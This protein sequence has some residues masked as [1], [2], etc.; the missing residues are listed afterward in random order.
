M[1]AFLNTHAQEPAKLNA[2]E[3]QLGLKKLNTLGSV[4]YV[5]AHPDDE[6][7]RLIAYLSNHALLNTA[8]L[9]I[10]RGD[11]GQNLVGPEIREMLGV[12]R[13][14]EL[15]QARKIDGGQQ[16]F[17]RANDFGYSKTPD[18][19]F[20]IWDRE[21]VLSD[22]VWTI[23]KFQPDVIITRFPTT[24]EGGH[25][26]HTASAILAEEAFDAA[27]D[28]NRFPEQLAHVDVWQTRSLVLNTHPW[29]YSRRGLEFD[30]T[31]KV[32]LDVG[33]Y[34]QLLGQSYTEIAAASR[35][36]HKSQGFGSTGSR[37][38]ELEY[39]QHIKGDPITA[40]SFQGAQ[41]SWD[42]VKNGKKVSALLQQAYEDFNPEAPDAVVPAL[43]QALAEL[44]QLQDNYYA[45]LKAK[46]VKKLTQAALG[47][48]LEASLLETWGTPG[49][50]I[51]VKLEATN[52]SS[53][54]ITLES[55]ESPGLEG[56]NQ[57]ATL[58]PNEKFTGEM[59][60]N[61]PGDHP[62]SQP[63]W[64]REQGSVGMF[65]VA[66]PLM[67]GKPENDAALSIPM[68]VTVSGR[69]LEYDI[70]VVHKRNDAVD[71]EIF[72][73][74]AIAP[75][76]TVNFDEKVHVFA[77]ETPR[78]V[79]LTIKSGRESVGGQLNLQVPEGWKVSPQ[80][81]DFD[82]AQKGEEQLAEFTIYP[83]K[84]PGEGK[85]K[86][87]A[88]VDGQ[89]YSMEKVTISYDHIPDQMLLPEAAAKVVK[90][91]ILTRGQRIGYIMGAGDDIPASL[92][93]I[94]YQVELIP[95]DQINGSSLDVYDAIILGVRA[96]NTVKRLQFDMDK[97][98]AYAYRG[99]TLVV[100]YNTNFR[101]VTQD[102]APYPLEISR[103]RVA[104]EGA[105][106]RFLLPDHP[107][108]NTPNKIEPADFE[109]WVQER[110]LYFPNKWDEKYQAVLSTNDP[111]E[112]PKNGSL[113]VAPYGEGYYVYTGL[114]WF[115][116][117]PAGVPGAF[118]LFTNII[119]L[120]QEEPGD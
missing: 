1:T 64:L 36:M 44:D 2:A 4:L 93:Q 95:P 74:F 35:S 51:K 71:G 37:G 33:A 78:K 8:Y 25:G 70:P 22:V 62:Y 96:L 61:I 42:R 81:I 90:L 32:V 7:T 102:F 39:L 48:Y 120:G 67:I 109:A 87:I 60:L 20:T 69:T 97:L 112:S 111:G 100:Q 104:V 17:T 16:F 40:S 76:V 101:M 57:G 19:T 31:D 3:I 89:E 34:N 116:E 54:D 98:L 94:G 117:L 72:Q 85:I 27:A 11:G 82:L 12:I 86:A 9:S 103:D 80:T 113:L 49:E 75:E 91:N 84:E 115:R 59:T 63:Y 65:A 45:R 92:R 46:E 53:M 118:R 107:V 47:L 26:Q 5:A 55:I 79:V 15:L 58:G 52:R 73:P 77:N 30:P 50:S 23:R 21:A 14:Q 41:F 24:G 119:S 110:G 66:D 88:K 68:K 99:G 10:T 105:P 108:L 28:P 43:I 29:F 83:P 18:E 114:S 13:T 6:N 38:S 106:V 56:E